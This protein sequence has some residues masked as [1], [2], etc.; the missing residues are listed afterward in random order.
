[1]YMCSSSAMGEWGLWGVLGE[2]EEGYGSEVGKR[3]D[4]MVPGP[5]G[6]LGGEGG[7]CAWVMKLQSGW[8]MGGCGWVHSRRVDRKGCWDMRRVEGQMFMANEVTKVV[9]RSPLSVWRSVGVTRS[10]C[11]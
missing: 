1:M 8:R 6:G 2:G 7:W 10:S 4:G 5:R 3:G 11:W 9:A